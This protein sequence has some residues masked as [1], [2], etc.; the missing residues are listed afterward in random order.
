MAWLGQTLVAM[1]VLFMIY[2]TIAWQLPSMFV[3]TITIGLLTVL[4]L[5]LS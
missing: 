1:F 4:Y 5:W 3:L 2:T